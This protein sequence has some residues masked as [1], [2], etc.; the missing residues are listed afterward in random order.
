MAD[1]PAMVRTS[2]G[3]AFF[4]LNPTEARPLSHSKRSLIDESGE[5]V[6][7]IVFFYLSLLHKAGEKPL[8]SC[9]SLIK[10]AVNAQESRSRDR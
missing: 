4:R 10:F 9:Q 8:N 6:Y 7:I 2:P 5:F 1:N 3:L